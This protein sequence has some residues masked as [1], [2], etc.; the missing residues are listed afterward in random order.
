MKYGDMD[1]LIQKIR[2]QS[3]RVVLGETGK[4]AETAFFYANVAA[5]TKREW[6]RKEYASF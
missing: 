2:M 3:C 1:A 4:L 5:R 6:S